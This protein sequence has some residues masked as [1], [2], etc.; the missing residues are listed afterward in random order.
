MT[1]QASDRLEALADIICMVYL[2]DLYQ[3]NFSY[4]VWNYHC[5]QRYLKISHENSRIS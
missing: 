3:Q 2:S 1:F 4:A 5:I